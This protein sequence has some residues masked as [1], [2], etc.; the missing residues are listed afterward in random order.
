MLE[1]NGLIWRENHPVQEEP[2]RFRFVRTEAGVI[3]EE[4][5]TKSG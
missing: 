4:V 2:K 1:E 3:E 5:T